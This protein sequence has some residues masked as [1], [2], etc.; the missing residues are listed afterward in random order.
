MQDMFKILFSVILIDNLVLSRFLGVCSFLGLTKDLK[1]S[2]GMSVAVI[3][4][5]LVSTAVTYPIYYFLLEPAGLGYL[6]TVIFI[7][8][9]AATVQVL[10]AVIRK[11]MPPLYDAMGI[12]L[13]LITTNCAILGVMLINIQESYSFVNAIMSSLG[14]GLGY[15][16]AMF[17]FVGVREKLETSDIPESFKGLPSTLVAASILSVAFMGFGGVIENLFS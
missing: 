13:P 8:V 10:E 17:L 9:I 12:F 4:V 2:M 6:Q 7:L 16:L 5:M 1:N 3:F 11:V 14:A 15:T